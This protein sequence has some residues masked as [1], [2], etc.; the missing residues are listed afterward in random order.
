MTI[1]MRD[2]LEPTLSTLGRREHHVWLLISRKQL[3]RPSTFQWSPGQ[4]LSISPAKYH[5]F[6]FLFFLWTF[7][8]SI[9]H[10]CFDFENMGPTIKSYP[11]GLV[12]I[13]SWNIHGVYEDV[14]KFQVNK[15]ESPS[16]LK[17]LQAHDILCVQE[18]HLA[19]HE[20]PVDHLSEFKAIP[21]C[22][23]TSSNGRNYGGMLLLVR[24]NIRP[25][26]KISGTGNPDI[27]G[28]TL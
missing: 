21:H 28:I 27:L 10:F 6:S 24:K 23:A 16:F 12:R 11:K 8:V 9:T 2:A 22:R 3:P 15:L 18:T 13:G 14:N 19:A 25:G 5:F 20:L 7:K 17:V 1:L 26:V 4:E